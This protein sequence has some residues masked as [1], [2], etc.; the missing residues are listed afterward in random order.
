MFFEKFK[1]AL[2]K[3]YWKYNKL[4]KGTGLLRLNTKQRDLSL[5]HLSF[6]IKRLQKGE[7]YR[8]VGVV[9]VEGVA[10]EKAAILSVSF[11][12]K[13]GTFISMGEK[14]I[15]FKP[16]PKY[17]NYK[18]LQGS[19]GGEP[20]DIIIPVPDLSVQCKIKIISKSGIKSFL[21]PG[22]YI[23]KIELKHRRAL[24][25]LVSIIDENVVSGSPINISTIS[26]LLE[27][28]LKD[29]DRGFILVKSFE[30]YMTTRPEVACYLGWLAWRSTR[31]SDIQKL[32][33]SQ[34][35]HLGKMFETK[36]F[37]DEIEE[38][39]VFPPKLSL[40]RRIGDE[41]EKMEEGF[42]YAATEMNLAY[43]PNKEVL[44]LLHNCLP[45]NS[46]GYATRTHGLLKG[47]DEVSD[48]KVHGLSRPGY[49]TDH[50]KHISFKLPV[51]IPDSDLIDGIYYFRCNQKIRKSSLTLSEYVEFFSKEIINL[52]KKHKISIIHAASNYPN[53][54]AAN[55]AAKQL[56]IR[57]IYEVRGLWEITRLSRQ[58]EW[59]KTEQF[60]FTAKMEAEACRGAD[61]VFTI[62]DALKKIMIDRGVEGNK[63]SIVP[64]CVHSNKFSPLEP[65]LKLASELGISKDDTVIGYIGSIVNYEGLDTLLYALA[66]LKSRGV[67]SFKFLLVG[68]GAELGYLRSLIHDL[69][70][71]DDVIITG[72]VAHELVQ[73]YYSL[74]EIAPFPRKPYLVCEA[75]S[76]L[77]PFEAM[78]SEKAVIVSSCD[79][80][81]EIVEHGKNG[82]VFQKGSVEAL[83]DSLQLLL[84]DRNLM[85]NLSLAGREWVCSERDWKNSSQVVSEV[86]EKLFASLQ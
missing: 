25:K 81:T 49:P 38:V 74:V 9:F 48:F 29:K 85:R 77:K 70:L 39:M 8:I 26:S 2:K 3:L 24:T 45:Y 76:P 6:N 60:A 20:Y 4:S 63:I 59:D 40:S 30:Y 75:V 17:G 27:P 71:T 83:A 56:G 67:N 52:A 58:K 66:K 18:Y 73:S 79:A 16:S 5:K 80:L 69:L 7:S 23:E 32:V 35:T 54:I 68:D 34:L 28:V 19:D 72:R 11:F 22:A 86:Y 55:I 21:K 65:D 44:Y 51:V 61:A 33:R 37:L 47:I 82:L 84:E 43:E 36:Q 78:A 12:D 14:S 15:G 42:V 46:G 31:N 1:S 10:I 62:T 64:N 53:G 41:I 13:N 57:S 50:K